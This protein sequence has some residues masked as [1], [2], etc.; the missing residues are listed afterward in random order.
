MRRRVDNQRQGGIKSD[1]IL[2]TPVIFFILFFFNSFFSL[3][4]FL[5]FFLS[6]FPFFIF[7]PSIFLVAVHIHVF[8]MRCDRPTDQPTNQP[9]D[10]PSGL[11]SCVHATK[12]PV[13]RA[14]ARLSGQSGTIVRNQ[15]WNQYFYRVINLDREKMLSFCSQLLFFTGLDFVFFIVLSLTFFCVKISLV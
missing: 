12:S 4:F 10:Q 6:Y 2:D 11:Q 14:L 15:H 9:T 7:L 3:P 1:S 8:P 5:P 13:K